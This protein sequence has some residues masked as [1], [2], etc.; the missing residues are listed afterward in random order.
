MGQVKFWANM[1]KPAGLQ[2]IDCPDVDAFL[3]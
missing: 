3:I 2:L 1:M